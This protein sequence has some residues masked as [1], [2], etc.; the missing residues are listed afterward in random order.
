MLRELGYESSALSVAKHYADFLDMFVIDDV[1][2]DQRL[3][4][5]RLGTR[6]LVTD[7]WMKSM[8]DRAR[9]AREVLDFARIE[10]VHR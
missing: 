9:L 6:V 3:E 2:C 5:E 7:T 1:D 10:N 8:E 4:I